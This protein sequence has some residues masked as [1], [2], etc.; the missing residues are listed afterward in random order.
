MISV[1][2]AMT[3]MI[4]WILLL[5][6]NNQFQ[7]RTEFFYLNEETFKIYSALASLS[8]YTD[9]PHKSNTQYTVLP[10]FD[11]QSLTFHQSFS[12]PCIILINTNHSVALPTELQASQVNTI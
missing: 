1:Q 4:I 2:H 6:N 3:V 7:L 10:N 9:D 11:A 8:I 5:S 12:Q